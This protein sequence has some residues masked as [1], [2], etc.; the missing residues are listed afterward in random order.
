[1]PSSS[2]RSLPCRFSNRNI[3]CITH[4][5]HA[6]YIF[7][8]SHPLWFDRPNNRWSVQVMKL[9]IMQSSPVSCHF[10]PLMSKY[11]PQHPV[12][13]IPSIY[14][15]PLVGETKFTLIQNSR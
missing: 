10:L 7:R 13:K 5:S 9:L 8:P 11:S 4:L 6:C 12:L 14:A 3:V 2:R 1:M 15:S